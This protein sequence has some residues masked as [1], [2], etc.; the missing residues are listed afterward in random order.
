MV[1]FTKFRLWETV[2]ATVFE[3]GA[4]YPLFNFR[5]FQGAVAVL[6]PRFPLR[7]DKLWVNYS[8]AGFR[9]FDDGGTPT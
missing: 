6:F 9:V 7:F 3:G 5:L 4:I 8:L 2:N 1:R